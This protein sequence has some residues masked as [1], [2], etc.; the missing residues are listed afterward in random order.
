MLER[1]HQ[2]AARVRIQARKSINQPALNENSEPIAE[3]LNVFNRDRR[4]E[5][6]FNGTINLHQQSS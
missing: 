4:D 6:G 2:S 5:R 3:T 1:M